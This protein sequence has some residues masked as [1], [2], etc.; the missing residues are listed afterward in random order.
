MDWV[1]VFWLLFLLFCWDLELESKTCWSRNFSRKKNHHIFHFKNFHGRKVTEKLLVA[2]L[3]L[4][5][6]K[7]TRTSV[8]FFCFLWRRMFG[9]LVPFFVGLNGCTSRLFTSNFLRHSKNVSSMRCGENLKNCM[10]KWWR[11]SRM[12]RPSKGVKFQ[13][14]GLCLV[15]FWVPNFRSFKDSG[16]RHTHTYTY[17]YI[18]FYG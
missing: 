8:D 7:K 9:F 3:H 1:G 2:V 14:P 5:N 15:V 16:F 4:R 11:F 10:G 12:P 13:P 18:L 6:S 17:I